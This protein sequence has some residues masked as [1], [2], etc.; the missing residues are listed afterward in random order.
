M[1]LAHLHI[2]SRYTKQKFVVSIV[3]T[4]FCLIFY[5]EICCQCSS[6]STLQGENCC[7]FSLQHEF[8]ST[9][10]VYEHGAP[11]HYQG[12]TATYQDITK[13]F[14]INTNCFNQFKKYSHKMNLQLMQKNSVKVKHFEKSPC[15]M[16]YCITQHVTVTRKIIAH[17]VKTFPQCDV[18]PFPNPL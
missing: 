4:Y 6:A 14:V 17:H 10:Y 9:Y 11:Q 3:V 7:M 8:S 16:Y 13:Q 15:V 5:P 18:Y 1:L 2:S 12:K